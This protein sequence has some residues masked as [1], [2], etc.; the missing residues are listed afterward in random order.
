MFSYARAVP[1]TGSG[2][3]AFSNKYLMRFTRNTHKSEYQ[4][5]AN[6]RQ[7][8]YNDKNPLYDDYGGRG[9]TVDPDWCGGV[10]A[11]NRFMDHIGPKPS[12]DLSLDR[13]DNDKGYH[14]GNVRWATASEQGF[15]KRPRRSKGRAKRNALIVRLHGEGSTIFELAD[16]FYLTTNSVYRILA[17]EKAA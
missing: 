10:E 14:P 4:A 11:F 9:I 15:N 16:I 8:C 6:A 3:F 12:P 7:R 2:L 5:L 1:L 13:I 17:A